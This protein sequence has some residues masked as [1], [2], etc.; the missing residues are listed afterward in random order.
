MP[1]PGT[2]CLWNTHLGTQVLQLSLT[3]LPPSHQAVWEWLSRHS[4][5]HQL[6]QTLPVFE[7]STCSQ[8]CLVSFCA[9]SGDCTTGHQRSPPLPFG[10]LS[11]QGSLLRPLQ[12]CVREWCGNAA[13][14]TTM[15]QRKK[16]KKVQGQKYKD[17]EKILQNFSS[18]L[19]KTLW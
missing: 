12:V 3:K 2:T 1:F 18:Y 7:C 17:Q 13:G 4:T 8:F 19:W 5:A 9:L 15:R 11:Q 6:N 14:E 10:P 16:T